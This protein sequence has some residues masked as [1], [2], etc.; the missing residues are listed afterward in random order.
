VSSIDDAL[1]FSASISECEREITPKAT[2]S[3]RSLI[4]SILFLGFLGTGAELLFLQHIGSWQE[5]IP[6]VLIGV[7]LV[8][9]TWHAITR[10]PG[11]V[12]GV[13]VVM[14]LCLIAGVAGIVLHYQSS[15]EFKLE[16][17]PAL[18]GWALFRA[19]MS[20]QTPPTLAPGVM[21]Q[22]GLL[23]LAYSYKHPLTHQNETREK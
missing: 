21:I 3:I 20:A 19:V 18:T 15:M 1:E 23:G 2:M 5:L 10:H 16:T 6:V 9:M 13:Q 22:L 17:N 4:L 7:N 12:R 11:S 14:G 8:I